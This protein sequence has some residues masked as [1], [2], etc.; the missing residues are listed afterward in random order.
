MHHLN[1]SSLKECFHQLSAD[2]AVGVD[3][4]TQAG[5]AAN[6][7][8]NLKDLI[9]RMKRMAYRPDP[10]RRV[11]IPKERLAVI[12]FPDNVRVLTVNG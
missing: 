7:D 3:G 9:D 11:L 10:V 8:A 5:Y 1:E 6:L 12:G 2:R 4:I